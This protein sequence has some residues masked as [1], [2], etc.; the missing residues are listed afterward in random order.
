MKSQT[1]RPKARPKAPVDVH[2]GEEIGER[3]EETT[4]KV[5]SDLFILQMGK[6]KS[7]MF[8]NCPEVTPLVDYTARLRTYVYLL[9]WITTWGR[10]P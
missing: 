7:R 5:Y 8:N 1:L 6:M 3:L 2:G 10:F 9:L 4:N